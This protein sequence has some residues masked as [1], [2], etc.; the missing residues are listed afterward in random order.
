MSSVLAS[1]FV[2]PEPLGKPEWGHMLGVGE[3]AGA[4]HAKLTRS[5]EVR[6]SHYSG[7]GP[8]K[9]HSP[10]SPNGRGYLRREEQVLLPEKRVGSSLATV[11][12]GIQPRAERTGSALYH[13]AQ[14]SRTSV[15]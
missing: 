15:P 7:F 11:K 14:C 2:T 6:S 4:C 3:G 10:A 13:T 12:S 9:L 5:A 1:T 8:I